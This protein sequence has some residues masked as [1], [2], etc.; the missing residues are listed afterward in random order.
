MASN[1]FIAFMQ[2]F[3]GAGLCGKLRRPGAPKEFIDSRSVEEY[4]A[5]GEFDETLS[6]YRLEVPEAK[7]AGLPHDVPRRP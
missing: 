7:A 4:L 5:S 1:G 2:G 6:R 3:T